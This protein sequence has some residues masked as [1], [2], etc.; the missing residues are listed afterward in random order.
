MYKGPS[1]GGGLS[2]LF[3]R[4]PCVGD[5]IGR[6][7][8]LRRAEKVMALRASGAL[9]RTSAA[10]RSCLRP[11]FH[12]SDDESLIGLSPSGSHH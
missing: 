2:T 11:G 7:M 1:I 9:L 3:I 4:P 6:R 5:L 8:F 10:E 12:V